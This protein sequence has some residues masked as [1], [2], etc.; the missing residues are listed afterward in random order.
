MRSSS[1]EDRLQTLEDEFNG[2]L[3][4]CLQECANGRWGLFG[5]NQQPEAAQALRWPEAVKLRELAKE[6]TALR[7]EFGHPN[8]NC[9]RF[10]ECCHKHGANLSGEPKRA[11]KFLKVLN[12]DW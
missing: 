8:P 12:A 4:P 7:A 3:I 5:Q 11:K 6:I 9:K 2:L 10:L 1:K